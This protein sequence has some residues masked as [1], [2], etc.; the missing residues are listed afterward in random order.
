VP[1][2]HR[3]SE[4]DPAL[5][6]GFEDIVR[7]VDRYVVDR[8][9][10]VPTRQ[11]RAR[12]RLPALL[13]TRE[14]A[15]GAA[16]DD[17]T[18]V[19][20]PVPASAAGR[21]EPDPEL[22]ALVHVYHRRL[23]RLTSDE[24]G[25]LASL[26]PHAIV[27]EDLLTC[28][29]P[30]ED[31]GGQDGP[32]VRLLDRVARQFGTTMPDGSGTLRLTEFHVCLAV[33]RATTAAGD[34]RRALRDHVYEKCAWKFGFTAEASDLGNELGAKRW[35]AAITK[36]FTT[37]LARLWRRLYGRRIDRGRRYR[38][39]GRMLDEPGRSFL[40]TSMSLRDAHVRSRS[41]GQADD[42][43]AADPGVAAARSAAAAVAARA[44]AVVRQILLTALIHD[45]TRA[46]RPPV[47]SVRRPRRR[48]PFVL[49]LPTVGG[50]DS[51]S[52]RL[53]NSFS[54]VS[55]ET[56]TCPLFVLGAATADIPPYAAG[57]PR[58][59]IPGQG[60]RPSDQ[61]TTARAVGSLL[62][63]GACGQPVE[64]VCRV[65]KV[66]RCGGVRGPGGW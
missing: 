61:G 63:A 42:G 51:P 66:E 19:G 25:H 7:I 56:T 3:T 23:V 29:P 28:D 1:L 22:S 41:Q 12:H 16:S 32:H 55:E 59:G 60:A 54:A 52:R 49:L 5:P 46:A 8:Q 47:W 48:W 2:P 17:P 37:L 57:L 30:G 24:T 62:A 58:P 4:S 45:L 9:K 13:F 14:R 36:A 65:F 18:T 44:E 39:V 53:L 15:A 34:E 26:A 38:W 35:P 27:D 20:M 6:S 40:N 43:A 64:A 11:R 10:G 33:L 50:E 31:A 21:G